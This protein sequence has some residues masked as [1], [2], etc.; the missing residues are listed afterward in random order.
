MGSPRPGA[1]AALDLNRPEPHRHRSAQAGRGPDRC[2]AAAALGRAPAACHHWRASE[3]YRL[4]GNWIWGCHGASTQSQQWGNRLTRGRSR[5][6]NS[7]S[8]GGAGENQNAAIEP[9]TPHLKI[10][11]RSMRSSTGDAGGGRTP[12]HTLASTYAIKY[13]RMHSCQQLVIGKAKKICT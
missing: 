13:H 12:E 8:G 3:P 6:R 7:L 5:G 10:P 9:R 1:G 4:N 11:T 2:H